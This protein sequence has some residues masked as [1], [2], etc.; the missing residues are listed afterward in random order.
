[1]RKVF[2]L[3]IALLVGCHSSGILKLG[4]DTYTASATAASILGGD[5]EA[6]RKVITEANEFCA[7]QGKEILVKNVGSARSLNGSGK[8]EITFRCLTNGDPELQRPELH[9]V[10]DVTIEDRRK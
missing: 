7:Q 1:M 2:A 10:P 9:Q 5:S 8:A 6:R 4:P 3:S